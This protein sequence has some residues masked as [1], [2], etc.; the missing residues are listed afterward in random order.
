MHHTKC[1]RLQKYVIAP[2]FATKLRSEIGDQ[3]YSLVADESTNEANVSC[4]A[5]CIRFY[6]T[7]KKSVVD[8]F[9]RLVPLE[10]ATANTLYQTVK[11]CLTEDGLDVKK[12]IGLGTDGASYMIGRTHSLSTLLRVD[13]PEL[14]LIKCVCH[15]LH[16]AA[17]KA[18]D[19][20]PTIIDFLVRETH[21]WFSNSPKRTNE[22]QAIY[23]VLENSVPKKVPGM[24]GTRWLARLEAVNVIID[25]WEA[26]KLHFELSASKERCHTTRT[27]HDAYRDDQ[28]KLYLLFVRKTLKEVVRVNKIFQAQA[29]DITKVTQ[30]LVAMYRNLMNIVVNPKH[31]SKCSDENLPKLKFLDHVMPCEAMNFGYEFNTFAVACSLTKV[32]VQYV[33]ERCKE[34]VIELINQVQMRLPDNVETLLMLKNFHPSIATSQIKD[35]VAQI[36]ARY[37]STFEDLDGLEN[38]WSSIG[39]QQWPKSCLGNLISFWTEVN[40]KEN[41]A[42]EKLFSNISSLVL[43]LLSLPFSNATVERI[44]S[45]MNVVHSKPRN[46]LNVRSVE[47][48]L[49]IRYGLIHYFQ[50]CVNFEPSDDMIRNFNSKG[51]AEEEEDNIIALDV[52]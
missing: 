34:F 44:F 2:S 38:E 20:L 18:S 26:L 46:R 36:G 42:G 4:L 12:M 43:S 28:N 40:E 29:A 13:N 11:R 52:Q 8:T 37:R 35:S 31:L 14:T 22:Y 6:S 51:T 3:F 39:L 33:K 30:D 9:Y 17:S 25:Q 1:A 7:C 15:S 45:Q 16:L 47:A 19:C 21:N 5:L 10:D 27:L 41:S 48:L 23:K 49:Q 32:Q 24:S 50:S